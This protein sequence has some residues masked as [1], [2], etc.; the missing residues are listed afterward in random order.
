[1]KKIYRYRRK[2]GF[3]LIEL[4]LVVAIILV[5]LGFMVPK[6]SA[7]Q[8]KVKTTKAVNTAKQIETAAMASYSDNG[9]KFV[10]GDVQDCISTLTSAEASTVG[11]DSGDQLLNINYKSDDD[12]YTVEINAENNSCIVRKGNEQVFPKE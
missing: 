10:Q 6:F 1:M 9:G 2:K 11:G 5:L 3:T 12:T 4:M 8:N 7:Y